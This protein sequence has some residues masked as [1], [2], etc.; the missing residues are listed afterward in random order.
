MKRWFDWRR[1]II[2]RGET[3]NEDWGEENLFELPFITSTYVA[4]VHE[5]LG[6]NYRPDVTGC[7]CILS[8]KN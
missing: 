7:H 5:L 6:H 1:I 2:Y 3:I 4:S 8:K